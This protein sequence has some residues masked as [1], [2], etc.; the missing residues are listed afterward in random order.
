MKKVSLLYRD[1]DTKENLPA[2]ELSEAIYNLNIDRM[3]ESAC[4]NKTCAQYFLSVLGRN[5]KS[6]KTAVYRREILKDF[7]KNPGL[8]S[9]LMQVFRSY[10]N[11]QSETEEMT[12]E[13]FRYGMPANETGMLDCIYEQLYINAHFARNVIAYFSEIEGVFARYEVK[14][15]GLTGMKNFCISVKESKCID[16]IE[17]AAERFKSE[18][19]ESYSFTVKCQLD[20]TMS[21][22]KSVIADI[23]EAGKGGKK[24][25][26]AV[27]K[28]KEALP[29]E[30]D[31]GNSAVDS[32]CKTTVSALSE[33]SSLFSD[34]AGGI[35]SAFFGIGKE[36]SFYFSAIEIASYLE[37][38]GMN[39]CFPTVL[40]KEEDILYASSVY[41]ILLLTEGKNKKTIVTNSVDISGS[42]LMI[43]GDNNCGK[44]S[45]LRAVGTAVIFAQSGL[46]VAADDMTVSIREGIFTH[47]S[48]AEKDFSDAN[49]VAG[50]FE[51][52]VIDIAKIV[53]NLT[54]YSLVLLNETFQTTAYREGAEG[55][56]EILDIL[57]EIK[58]K[59]IFVTHIKAMLTDFKPVGVNVLKAEKYNLVRF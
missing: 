59:Y 12:K 10:D 30:V 16:E 43:T 8:L 3:V 2:R 56:K 26:F 54:P 1:S 6:E 40:E 15:E 52:E 31:I 53:D 55:M 17:K 29:T 20:K 11:L 21:A 19:V 47:F 38:G 32:V 35:Y 24:K 48:S 36:L 37:K 27:F 9:E 23:A 7:L 33:L 51:S 50:R 41:D 22:S 44:T 5:A 18:S 45:F 46:F 57:P 58:V 42:G 34:I 4:K 13:V 14:S 28:K 49:N 39:Y 25:L